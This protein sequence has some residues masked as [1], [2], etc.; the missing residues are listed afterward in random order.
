MAVPARWAVETVNLGRTFRT[1][2]QPEKIALQ[3]INLQ[4]PEGE[5][6]GLLGPNG[7]GKSTLIKILSTLLLP[8]TGSARVLGLDVAEEAEA[9]RWQINMVSGGETSGYGIL[10]VAENL[11]LFGQLY[12]LTYAE[13]RRR[14]AELLEI[15]GLQEAAGVRY[16]KLSTG[17][18]QKL[19]FARGFIS[20]PRLLFLDEPTLGLDVAISRQI[21]SYVKQWV[22][23]RPGR[24]LLLTTHYMAEADELCDRLA[25]IDGGRIIA[26]DTPANLK[27]QAVPELVLNLETSLLNGESQARLGALPGVRRVAAEHLPDRG[28]TRWTLL[29]ADDAAVAAVL[30]QVTA[31]G[32]AVVALQKSE[33]TL[34]DVFLKLCGRRLSEGG[35]G[36]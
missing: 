12:G 17:M 19:Q 32:A 11:H 23:E 31:A 18:K 15:V 5:V 33:P 22:R 9:L 16:N 30:A 24:T 1:R 25:I 14:I 13:S 20:D 36:A 3:G 34:E 6:F 26:L 21:R 27:R 35:A 4:I 28:R 8:S 2:G 29:V 10:T 7:A